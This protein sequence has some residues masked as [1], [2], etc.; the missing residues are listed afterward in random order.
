L[1][2][3]F[4]QSVQLLLPRFLLFVVDFAVFGELWLA[5]GV[6]FEVAVAEDAFK[7]GYFDLSVEFLGVA[8][9]ATR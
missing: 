5:Q 4:S 7:I 6:E 2:V 8:V 3:L 1:L 9:R